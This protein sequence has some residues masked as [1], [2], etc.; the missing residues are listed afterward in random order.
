MKYNSSGIPEYYDLRPF[1]NYTLGE[2]YINKLLVYFFANE[3]D[4]VRAYKTGTVTSLSAISSAALKDSLG[5]RSELLRVAFPRIFAIFFNQNRNHVFAD[6]NVRLALETLL[7]KE[8]IVEEV[9]NGYGTI[10]DSP[11]PPGTITGQSRPDTS[12]PQSTAA[13]QEAATELLES[14]GWEFNDEVGGWTDGEQLLTFSIATANTPELKR[15]AQIAA[16]TWAEAGIPVKVNVFETGDLNQNIIRPRDYEALLFGEVVGR[17]LDLFAFWHSSQKDD[18]GLNIAIYTNSSTDDLLAEARTVSD[19]EERDTLY[20]KFEEEI[21]NDA[22]AI[23]LYAPDFLYVVPEKLQ[24]VH[25]GLVATQSERFAG[26]HLWH[27]QT[28]RVWHFFQ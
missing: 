16:T 13:R 1:N 8:Q 28:E 18:P 2:P 9:L 19:R 26:V 11:I 5:E 21:Q 20:L 27:T 4:L 23:F 14:A 24:G 22:P 17:S 3:D 15:A 6:K 7:D 12:S 10:I 25:I